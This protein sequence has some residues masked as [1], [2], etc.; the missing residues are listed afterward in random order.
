MVE[1]APQAKKKGAHGAKAK[2]KAKGAAAQRQTSRGR[3]AAQQQTSVVANVSIGASAGR[4]AARYQ[5][6]RH[7][8]RPQAPV[9]VTVPVSFGSAGGMMGQA[10]SRGEV[11]REIQRVQQPPLEPM[12]AAVYSQPVKGEQMWVPSRPP[13]PVKTEPVDRTPVTTRMRDATPASAYM[14]DAHMGDMRDGRSTASTTPSSVLA[15]QPSSASSMA[16]SPAAF[17]EDLADQLAQRLNLRSAT[18]STASSDDSDTLSEKMRVGEHLLMRQRLRRHMAPG[19]APE[20][21]GPEEPEVPQAGELAQV[22]RDFFHQQLRPEPWMRL[23]P[24][25]IRVPAA[26]LQGPP[27]PAAALPLPAPGGALALPAPDPAEEQ[28]QALVPY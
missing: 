11:I 24:H 23:Q 9:V 27:Q 3:I 20:L 16:R 18:P 8:A 15:S 4:A 6:G 1:P 13:P 28:Q 17:V 22:P 21:P 5:M 10:Q 25:P 26:A 19:Q 14:R 2:A 7:S 12:A